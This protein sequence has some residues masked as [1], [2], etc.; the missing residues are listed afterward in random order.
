MTAPAR[1]SPAVPGTKLTLPGTDFFG[2]PVR[3][4]LAVAGASTFALAG[5][6]ASVE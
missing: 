3:P 1:I 6:G 2:L 5:I 4:G